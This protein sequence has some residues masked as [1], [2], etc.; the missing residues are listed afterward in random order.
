MSNWPLE[1]DTMPPF[2]YLKNFIT[3]EKCEEIVEEIRES[4]NALNSGDPNMRRNRK[5]KSGRPRL[6][7]EN[8]PK[9]GGEK[10][11]TKTLACPVCK[12]LM[13][14]YE[15]VFDHVKKQHEQHA[16]FEAIMADLKVRDI[17]TVLF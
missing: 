16:D 6:S 15:N 5:L 1:I 2:V 10:T 14:E 9:A 17:S 7:A 3:P 13:K 12:K 11:R 8:N 4:E